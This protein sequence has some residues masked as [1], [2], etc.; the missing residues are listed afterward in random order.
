[1]PEL[2]ETRL[3]LSYPQQL[4]SVLDLLHVGGA[5]G[6]QFVITMGSRLRGVLDE[7]ALRTAVD[8]VVARHDALRAVIS[9]QEQVVSPPLPGRFTVVDIGT[10]D[11]EDRAERAEKFLEELDAGTYPADVPPLLWVFLGRMAP[12]DAVLGVVVHHSV[13]DAW[14]VDLVIRELAACYAARVEGGEPQLP[15]AARYAD[16]VAADQATADRPGALDYWQRHLD[17][18]PL[19]TVPADG[20]RPPGGRPVKAK[21]RFV[22]PPELVADLAATSRAARCTQFIT[23]LTGYVVLLHRH[24]GDPD[25]LTMT[26]NSGRGRPEV[27]HLVGYLLNPV[28]LRFDLGGDPTLRDCLALARQTCLD[29]YRYE[30][31]VLKLIQAVPAAA[32]ALAD[33]RSLM[34]PFQ[35]LPTQE[36]TEELPFGPGCTR[37]GVKRHASRQQQGVAMPLD[38]LWT[39]QPERSGALAGTIDYTPEVFTEATAASMVTGFL[40]VV[41]QLAAHPDRK[42]SEVTLD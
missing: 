23:L 38:G 40:S 34:V 36:R 2:T 17:G 6:P 8:D 33:P 39:L 15:P 16:H 3:P 25:V 30:V 19:P 7:Q 28:P 24:T 5:R 11:P 32:A 27:D 37:Q 18:M 29:A 22:I 12:D 26:L 42:L 13:T 20:V 1:M 35:Y 4:L 21:A 14:S 41:R 31:P 10:P 9:D